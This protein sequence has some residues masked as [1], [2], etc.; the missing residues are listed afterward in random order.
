[1]KKL[2]VGV[3]GVGHL[4]QHHARL[5]AGMPGA[6]LVG[7][8]D[9]DAKR[10]QAVADRYAT[11]VYSDANALLSRVD[12]VSVA[13]PTSAHYAVV[14]RCLEAGAH[15]LVEKP[16]AMTPTEAR[17]LATA[18]SMHRCADVHSN[19]PPARPSGGPYRTVQSR[20]SGRSS[21]H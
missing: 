15:V 12:A 8:C 18:A 4:G 16:I 19:G 10:A 3:I 2:R 1:M 20:Y 21:I 14:K 5:Y 11:S 9:I 7:V 6:T 13:V 17:D